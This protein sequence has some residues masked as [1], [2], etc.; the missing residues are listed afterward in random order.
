MNERIF[1]RIFGMT[2][3]T[4]TKFFALIE[5][6]IEVGQSTNGRNI[7]PIERVLIFFWWTRAC[8]SALHDA[9]SHDVSEGTIWKS[10]DIVIDAIYKVVPDLIKLPTEE[11]A[12]KEAKTYQSKNGFPPIAWGA[13]DGTHIP[14]SL[15]EIELVAVNN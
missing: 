5:D 15:L 12:L 8:S 1:Q 2:R 14:V 4:F 6:N 9:I 13:I 7:L 10:I 11:Q 3:S